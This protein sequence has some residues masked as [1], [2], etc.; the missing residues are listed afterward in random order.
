MTFEA[1]LKED[2]SMLDLASPMRQ[3][4]GKVAFVTGGSSGIGLGIVR[5]LVNAGMKVAFT[6]KTL[7]HR[8]RAIQLLA[9]H[10]EN[11]LAIDVDVTDRAGMAAA[12]R[13][14]VNHFG[15]V[16]VLVNNAAVGLITGLADATYDDWDWA[17]SVNIDGVFNGI[18]EFLPLLRE[19]GE[20][21]HI[22]TT[23]SMGGLVVAKGGV[24]SATKFAVVGMM[25]G[26]RSELAG[27]NIG[28]SVYCPGGVNSAILRSER[29]RPSAL[30]SAGFR[31]SASDLAMIA[32]ME[33]RHPDPESGPGMDPLEA[34]EWVLR[35]IRNN[36]LYILSHPE[37]AQSVRDRAE[38]LL[39][40][41]P[42][43]EM[44][45]PQARLDEE[46]DVL[47]PKM[48][49]IERKRLERRSRGRDPLR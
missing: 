36:D 43:T 12:S 29:N 21:G 20:G 16:H 24:Y 1:L 18:H 34:G 31:L 5:A 23:S 11:I 49:L 37:F 9:G 46:K 39:A 26:L 15:K 10:E 2:L 33:R 47:R 27:S 35:G 25:E 17:T 44:P 8:D 41:F 48:Y 3:V 19:H 32:E 40:S 28:V 30:P 42:G 13:E 22:V 4:T 38:A 14:A 6:Y 45:V 7:S